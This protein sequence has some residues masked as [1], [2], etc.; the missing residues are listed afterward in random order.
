MTVTLTSFS[1]NTKIQS[2]QANANFT[3]LSN[4]IRPTFVFTIDEVLTTGTNKTPILIVPINLTI[5]K[6]WAAIKTAS[7]GTAVICDVNL[8]GFCIWATKQANR[9]TIVAGSTSGNTTSFDTTSVS[10]GDQLTLDID[11]IGSSTPG[12]SIT[13]QI[14]TS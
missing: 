1:P 8:N 13:I 14:M 7:S 3:N 11:Q 6:V 2:T 4:Q 5:E 10:A 9:I 12:T